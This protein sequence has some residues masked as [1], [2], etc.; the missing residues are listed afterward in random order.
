M[1]FVVDMP[2]S[3]QLAE[4]LR[5]RGHDAFHISERGLQR[6]SDKNIFDL[7]VEERRIIITADLDFSRIFALSFQTG[8]TGLIL[9]REGNLSD[10]QMIEF[11]ER[12][13]DTIP[14]E[15][16]WRSII[17]VEH[18]RIRITPLPV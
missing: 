17:V 14:P 12:V 8:E 13:L 16:I 6:S 1:K 5:S 18:H 10:S 3:R 9:F 11:L 15:K 4:V 7:A 2:L